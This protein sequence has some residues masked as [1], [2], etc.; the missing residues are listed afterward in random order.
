MRTAAAGE[1]ENKTLTRT[2]RTVLSSQQVFSPEKLVLQFPDHFIHSSSTS[3]LGS[4]LK[5]AQSTSDHQEAVFIQVSWLFSSG[6]VQALLLC[7][8]T[9]FALFLSVVLVLR[10]NAA[11]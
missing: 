2:Y 4:L 9:C 1:H 3:T 11:A 6:F 10:Q 8:S 7:P 5:S